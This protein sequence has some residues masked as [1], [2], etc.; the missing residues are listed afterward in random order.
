M[1]NGQRAT[2][3]KLQPQFADSLMTKKTCLR[4]GRAIFQQKEPKRHENAI[5]LRGKLT[6]GVQ[7]PETP[8]ATSRC[9]RKFTCFE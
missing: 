6:T 7:H 1:K 9:Y 8:F 4:R 3:S 2:Q 5:N